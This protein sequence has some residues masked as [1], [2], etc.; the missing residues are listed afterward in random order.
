MNPE[1]DG[2]GLFLEGRFYGPQF[3]QLTEKLVPP[4]ARVDGCAINAPLG[5]PP[6]APSLTIVI[7]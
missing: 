2:A 7:S 3:C 6:G 4:A 5:L 1:A